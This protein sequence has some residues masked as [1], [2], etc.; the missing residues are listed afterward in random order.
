M[1]LQVNP[2]ATV[3][4]TATVKNA[5]GEAVVGR[6]VFFGSQS[7][8]SGATL[9]VSK[10]NTDAAGEATILYSAG[11][12]L[13]VRYRP[14][15]SLQRRRRWKPTS[16]SARPGREGGRSPSPGRRRPFGRAEQHPHGHGDGRRRKSRQRPV[17][18][19]R[20]RLEPERRHP[21]HPQRRKH[22]RERPSDRRL[23]GRKP[24]PAVE[25]QDIV[26]ASIAGTAS[27][28]VSITRTAAPPWVPGDADC[29]HPLAAGRTHPPRG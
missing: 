20:L 17:R 4:L 16:P 13:R 29:R 8:A 6:E 28:V 2:G 23:Q 22:R 26:E 3:V 5:S 1:A 25:V 7:N 27:G 19:L 21:D 24:H 14:G 9:N 12:S 18:H 15:L 11:L 10:A